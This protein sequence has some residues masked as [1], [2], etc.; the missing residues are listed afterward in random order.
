MLRNGSINLFASSRI[1]YGMM[2]GL[3]LQ[4][5]RAMTFAS[6]AGDADAELVAAAVA[7][8]LAAFETLYRRHAPR[9][10]GALLRLCGYDR[11]CAEDLLQE[12]FLKAWR[13]LPSFRGHSAFATWI[14]RIAV[15]EA[16]A[17]L[18]VRQPA[19]DAEA[20]D[21]SLAAADAAMCPA[22]RGELERAVAALPP[23]ARSVLVLHDIEGWTHEEIAQALGLATGSCKAHLH[24][25]RAMLR[26][27]L[28]SPP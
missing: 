21:A 2:Y 23:R 1:Q 13:A 17:L 9:V 19:Q 25:A 16:L 27:R 20:L 3:P 4:P 22:E 10:H 15:N 8:S 28:E 5:M 6:D 18:R 11:A 26:A 14:Y 12:A 7:G 24:R